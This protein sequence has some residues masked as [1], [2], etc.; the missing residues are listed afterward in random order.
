MLKKDIDAC[1]PLVIKR[2]ADVLAIYEQTAKKYRKVLR[3]DRGTLIRQYDP[4]CD[5]ND[6]ARDLSVSTGAVNNAL[7]VLVRIARELE[8][9][10]TLELRSNGQR[11]VV[12][13]P[14]HN[15]LQADHVLNILAAHQ[16][17]GVVEYLNYS[18]DFDLTGP[19]R[20]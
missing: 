7:S 10:A 3:I 16:L 5:F 13:V 6:L 19:V 15:Q 11:L 1:W 8:R 14:V 20:R 12:I 9:T 4:S 2:Q 17:K 18:D